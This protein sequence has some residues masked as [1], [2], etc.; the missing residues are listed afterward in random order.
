MT[1]RRVPILPRPA[2]DCPR[3]PRRQTVAVDHAE[4]ARQRAAVQV[5]A[6]RPDPE[7]LHPA[8]YARWLARRWAEQGRKCGPAEG[9]AV[10]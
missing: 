1:R 5:P 9:R 10:L 2:F 6:G 7:P 3:P 4:L 8:E